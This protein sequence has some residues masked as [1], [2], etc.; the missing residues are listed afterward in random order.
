MNKANLYEQANGVQ[1]RDAMEI[2]KEYAPLLSCRRGGE[3]VA[4]LDIG[5]GSG[6]VLV[7]FVLPVLGRGTTVPVG[8]ALGT[9]I[10]EQMVRYARESYRH[11]KTVEFD[12]LDIGAK[13]EASTLARWGQFSHV[14]SF[15]CLH[16]VQNQHTAF[17][18]IYQLLK[19]GG[20]CLLVF[21][22]NNPIFDIYNQLSRSPKWSK[23]MYDVEKYI[24]PYQ[25][26]ENPASEIEDLLCT[27]GFQHYQI[28]VRDKLY[29]YEGLDNL[30]RAVLAVNPFSERM[31][32]ELQDKFLLDYIAVVREMYLAKG[33]TEENDANL[34]F[35]SPYK[36]VVVYAKK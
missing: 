15:Y 4:L 26:C 19:T 21:L 10:S 3:D 23:Y 16:W 32:A 27:V 12:T 25:Y 24:S 6:D 22:A 18:N 17:S 34:Q 9:D 8:R 7:D 33:A 30:K 28:Q 2:L 29:V 14:T 35:I 31:P 36:L 1:R 13:L 20:D 11:L 5:C